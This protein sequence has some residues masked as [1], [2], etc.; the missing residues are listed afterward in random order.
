MAERA[1]GMATSDVLEDRL[2]G[3]G[4]AL[5]NRERGTMASSPFQELHPETRNETNYGTVGER[6]LRYRGT[7]DEGTPR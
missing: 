7:N 2:Q 5:R 4:Q 6:R 1:G 3:R